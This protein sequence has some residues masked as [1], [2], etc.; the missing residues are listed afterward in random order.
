MLSQ[1][2]KKKSSGILR[3]ETIQKVYLNQFRAEFDAMDPNFF[4][5][6]FPG[7]VH[8]KFT[9]NLGFLMANPYEAACPD[10]GVL[11]Y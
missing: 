10:F 2:S 4:V 8:K 11:E 9:S 7:I 1:K 3:E 6:A 5:D